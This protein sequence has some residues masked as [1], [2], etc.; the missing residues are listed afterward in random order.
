MK[1]QIRANNLE[2][3]YN[4]PVNKSND[5]NPQNIDKP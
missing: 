5:D 2:G 4:I 1:D 3:L